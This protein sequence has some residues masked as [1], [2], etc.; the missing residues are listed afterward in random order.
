MLICLA[1]SLQFQNQAMGAFAI[2]LC[3]LLAIIM[4]PFG[5]G[6]SYQ[7]GKTSAVE[8][9]T[10]TS[11]STQ[12][13]GIAPTSQALYLI[14]SHM[15]SVVLGENNFELTIHSYRET[16][17]PIA[18]N[19]TVCAYHLYKPNG[20]HTKIG[21]MTFANQF[22]WEVSFDKTILNE[23]GNYEYRIHCTGSSGRYGFVS[24]YITVLPNSTVS[25][26]TITYGVYHSIPFAMVFLLIGLYMTLAIITFR[27]GEKESSEQ[28][29]L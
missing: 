6:V 25:S 13:L 12:S 1:L 28:L 24:G 10:E 22:D 18:S 14:G 29:N 27:K 19:L 21:N 15:N 8:S 5:D 23:T 4:F 20:H 17:E 16:G 9:P 11:F 3:L 2:I 26:S 7:T